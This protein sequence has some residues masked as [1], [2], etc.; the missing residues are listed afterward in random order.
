MTF[1]EARASRRIYLVM[2]SLAFF[3]GMLILLVTAL[4]E[5]YGLACRIAYQ[6]GCLSD[7]SP[8]SRL[9]VGYTRTGLSSHGFGRGCQRVAS[10]G[11]TLC[12]IR[13]L[14]WDWRL[15]V[16]H[17]FHLKRSAAYEVDGRGKGAFGQRGDGCFSTA[18]VVAAID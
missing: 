14:Y 9:F 15:S 12:F 8:P 3:L 5:L 18:P 10:P 11:I 7:D 4:K 2:G 13:A 1:N 16:S 17:S 6:P